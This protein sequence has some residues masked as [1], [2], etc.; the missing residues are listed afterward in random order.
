MEIIQSNHSYKEKKIRLKALNNGAVWR[1]LI[2]EIFPH[3][4]NARFLGVYFDS[5]ED[6]NAINEI[7]AANELIRKGEFAQAYEKLMPF[8][9]DFRAYNSIGVSLMMQGQF[10][11]ALEWFEKAV[12]NGS[13]PAKQNIEAIKAK[14][15]Y[16]AKQRRIIEEYLKKYE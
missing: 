9:A 15:E 14:L 8:N 11:E 3:L 2:D 7:N 10:E 1:Q 12:E 4:R 16:E 6:D 13:E 5:A